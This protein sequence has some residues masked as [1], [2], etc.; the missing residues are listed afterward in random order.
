MTFIKSKNKKSSVKKSKYNAKKTTY[1]GIEF[2]SKKEAARY[3]ELKWLQELGEISNLR[4]QVKYPLFNG[5]RVNGKVAL[6]GCTYI[7]DFVYEEEG[8]TVVEDVKGCKTKEYQIKKKWFADK[9]GI[10]IKET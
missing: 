5:M 3:Q 7:A 8:Q 9:Y 6:R 1:D 2:A 10:L 4:L